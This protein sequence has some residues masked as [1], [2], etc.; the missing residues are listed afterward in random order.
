VGGFLWVWGMTLLGY[1][2]GK[3]DKNIDK[4]IHYLIAAV[5]VA[6]FMPAAYHAWKVRKNRV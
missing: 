1:T 2:V 3:A 5:I 6:S 4:H